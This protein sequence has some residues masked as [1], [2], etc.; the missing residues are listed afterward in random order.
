MRVSLSH[1]TPLYGRRAGSLQRHSC[2]FRR[3]PRPSRHFFVGEMYAFQIVGITA[4][5]QNGLPVGVDP[6]KTD[7]RLT[8]RIKAE[9][10]ASKDAEYTR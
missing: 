1:D 4:L 8:E 7:S 6:S 5:N 2:G 10:F 9:L 3:N